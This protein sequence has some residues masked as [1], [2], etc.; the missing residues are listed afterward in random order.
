MFLTVRVHPFPFRTRKLSSPVPTI[1]VWRRTGKIG[2]CQHKT[3]T[4]CSGF[5]FCLQQYHGAC[6]L[7][8]SGY[9]DLHTALLDSKNVA[10]N[11]ADLITP[12]PSPR[13]HL[14]L[15]LRRGRQR[16]RSKTA[17]VRRKDES[18]GSLAR[19]APHPSRL[20]CVKGAVTAR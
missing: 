13:R 4:F 5:S 12:H 20:P 17:Q 3:A 18:F 15:K 14:P 6:P 10:A 2:Q 16:L 19:A 9:T 7:L 8:R 11:A 1:L